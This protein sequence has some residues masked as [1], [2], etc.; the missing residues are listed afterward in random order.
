MLLRRGH[1]EDGV[2]ALE[3]V[4]VCDDCIGVR[5]PG[6]EGDVGARGAEAEI[7]EDVA[8]VFGGETAET[9]ELDGGVPDLR[10]PAQRCWHVVR[11]LFADGIEL[12]RDL[13]L[14]HALPPKIPSG[15]LAGSGSGRSKV[16]PTATCSPRSDES[17]NAWMTSRTCMP[18]SP[19]ALCFL[20]E[21]RPWAIS[22]RPIPLVFPV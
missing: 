15:D 11:G 6:V 10:D 21:R 1:G 16:L 17:R 2:G 8:E 4:H 3:G 5:L 18:S 12:E 14:P 22:A 20:P 9:C 13:V 7:V 19:L